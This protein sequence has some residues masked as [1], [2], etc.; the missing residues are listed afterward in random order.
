MIKHIYLFNELLLIEYRAY[1]ADPVCAAR[2]SPH[3]PPQAR[4]R[5]TLKRSI[6]LGRPSGPLQK[7][8]YKVI[9]VLGRPRKTRPAPDRIVSTP[10][11]VRWSHDAGHVRTPADGGKSNGSWNCGQR[12][13][14]VNDPDTIASRLAVLFISIFV[15]L[16]YY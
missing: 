1:A 16:P 2:P 8:M 11:T 7:I 15:F 9:I 6:L 13:H 14:K 5:S 10:T 4:I 3:L 12:S